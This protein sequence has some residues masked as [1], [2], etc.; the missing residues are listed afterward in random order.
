M[1]A[2]DH[3]GGRLAAAAGWTVV[4]H[5]RKAHKGVITFYF[6]H[7]P[8]SVP[9]DELR[10]RFLNWG[11]VVDLV[12]PARRNAYGWKFGF[13]RYRNVVDVQALEKKLDSMWIS[14]KKLWVNLQRFNRN[15]PKPRAHVAAKGNPSF[16]S[17]EVATMQVGGKSSSGPVMNRPATAKHGAGWR[18]TGGGH[19]DGGQPSVHEKTMVQA[20]PSHGGGSSHHHTASQHHVAS[21]MEKTVPLG[22]SRP[23]LASVI[24]YPD[25]AIAVTH[26]SIPS[27]RGDLAFTIPEDEVREWRKSFVAT[28][29]KQGEPGLI[30]SKFNGVGCYSLSFY[31]MGGNKILI[32]VAD[33]E[34]F[35]VLR[36]DL[37]T[38]FDTWFVDIVP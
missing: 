5:R 21:V 17:M 35:E 37:R 22:L 33:D 29:K 10:E 31:S 9:L 12:V 14:N 23:R 1:T 19:G 13:V 34:N 32:K 25:A 8:I 11:E 7:F 4:D 15:D 2:N 30:T 38:L 26:N 24:E 36:S 27:V 18:F 3:E 20:G 6:T 16:R 28:L